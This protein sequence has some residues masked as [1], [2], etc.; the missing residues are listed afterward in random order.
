MQSVDWHYLF[1]IHMAAKKVN[2]IFFDTLGK[3][4]CVLLS[5]KNF[6]L[7]SFNIEEM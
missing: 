5:V 2:S 7:P 4:T 3:I 1:D 6:L